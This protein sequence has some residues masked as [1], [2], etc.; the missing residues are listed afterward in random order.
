VQLICRLNQHLAMS[1]RYAPLPTPRSVPNVEFELND[2]FEEDQE[3]RDHDDLEST[4]LTRAPQQFSM[5]P[6]AY[7]FERD[8]DYPP[9]GSPPRPTAFAL[10]NDIGNSNGLLPTS[11]IRQ[12]YPR[13]SFFRRAIGAILPTHNS[14][15]ETTRVGGG[16]ENDGVF[17][18]VMAKPQVASVVRTENG[19]VL[20]VPEDSQTEVPP[21]STLVTRPGRWLLSHTLQSYADAQ[22][23]SVPP[24][25]ATT[26]VAPPGHGHGS[27]MIIDDLPTGSIWVFALNLII[28]YFFQ[29]VGFALTYLLHTSHAGKYGALGGFGLTL[30]QYGFFY[31]MPKAS[32]FDENVA[33]GAPLPETG[34]TSDP[35][36]PENM[37]VESERISSRETIAFVSIVIGVLSPTFYFHG[38]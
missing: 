2:A 38:F 30:I 33:V 14:Q 24:Y 8:Y 18:N 4:P 13:R 22:L 34:Q 15:I 5:I 11:S 31:R 20:V 12:P 3:D 36:S 21:V 19:E 17:A 6:G 26:V 29:V 27:D 35:L 10:P 16:I 32:I 25:W 7:D 23:D 37:L 1:A 28:S 9:P